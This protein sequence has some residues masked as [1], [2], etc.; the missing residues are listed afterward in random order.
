[1]VTKTGLQASFQ[2]LFQCANFPSVPPT[3]VHELAFH[4]HFSKD[5]LSSQP[6]PDPST[7]CKVRSLKWH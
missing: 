2:T 1:M 6:P 4:K 3:Y 7:A 5:F